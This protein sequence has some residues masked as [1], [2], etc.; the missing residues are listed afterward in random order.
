[1]F[2][3]ISG[4]VGVVTVTIWNADSAVYG[5]QFWALWVL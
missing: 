3:F 4:V 1:M 2:G 5:L